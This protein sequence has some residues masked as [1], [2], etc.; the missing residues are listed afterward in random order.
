[1]LYAVLAWI[2]GKIVITAVVTAALDDKSEKGNPDSSPESNTFRC[3]SVLCLARLLNLKRQLDVMLA[4]RACLPRLANS[5]P[6][7]TIHGFSSR[8]RRARSLILPTCMRNARSLILP[9][10]VRS[11]T[12]LALLTTSTSKE[13]YLM[14]YN[15]TNMLFSYYLPEF[16]IY[17]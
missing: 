1:M 3:T 17:S 10:C 2:Q 15:L 11:A 4:I 5:R 14:Y 6:I 8:G 13:V 9:T 7:I 12:A 16:R